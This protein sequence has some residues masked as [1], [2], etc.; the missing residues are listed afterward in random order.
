M[1]DLVD[2]M[3]VD[4]TPYE[5]P[6]AALHD[7]AVRRPD[8][9]ALD[10][11]GSDARLT[12]A[13][14]LQ[15]AQSIARGLI[16]RG[17]KPGEHVALLAENRIE[18][19][20]V[21]LACALGGFV[22]VPL[23]SHFRRDDLAYAIDHSDSVALFLSRSFRGN[24][25]L[26]TVRSLRPS[27][28]K[29]RQVVCFDDSASDAVEYS[30]L[31]DL[32]EDRG[33]P[34]PGASAQSAAALLY[35]SG[36]T[37]SAK[38]A[39]LDHRGMLGVAYGTARRLGVGPEDRWTSIIPLFHCAG[40]I[41][42]ILGC[43]Q[44]GACYVGVA[45]Y[46]PVLMFQT[47][48]ARCCTLLSGVPT[49]YLGMLD[50]PERRRYD[51]SSLRAGTCGGADTD[52]AMLERCAREFPIPRVAQVYGQTEVNTLVACPEIDDD[53]RFATAGRP[54]PGFDLRITDPRT[55]MPLAPGKIGQIEARGPL[56]MMGYYKDAAATAETITT[57]GWLKTGDLGMLTTEGRLVVAGGRLRDMIIRGGENIYPAEI[58]NLLRRHEA[59]AEVAVFGLPD[60]Y[61]GE[62]VAAAVQLRAN[63][64]AEDL[65][66]FC[67][68]RIARFKIPS[69]IYVV[70]NFPLTASGK[71]RKTELRLKAACGELRPLR[72]EEIS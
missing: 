45:A 61:Y 20:V 64:G 16:D 52:P 3:A 47:I 21:Q 19:P 51:L 68:G 43:L 58:E 72:K 33:R 71:I 49:T 17:I 12:F 66:S 27:L 4:L 11:P 26:E 5:N 46:D 38:G 24:P 35:T 8:A 6:G 23:N 36:T 60:T 40:C 34:L 48:E 32:G 63:L 42:N 7:Q 29:L 55:G 30:D 37:G 18:W 10:F 22:L 59:V 70:E 39:L 41:L 15:Q 9:I 44:A 50:H 25:Y 57:Q 28:P 67:D 62:S 2:R 1:P 65:R 31:V 56:V 13:Q 53:D 69:M 54:L 14:W